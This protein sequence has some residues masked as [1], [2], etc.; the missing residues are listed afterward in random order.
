MKL[1]ELIY[2]PV[3]E[4]TARVHALQK[5]FLSGKTRPLDYRIQQ[6]RKLYWAYVLSLPG[7]NG[8]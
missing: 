2:T 5:A 3:E 8:G 4:I 1:P 6:L 7:G